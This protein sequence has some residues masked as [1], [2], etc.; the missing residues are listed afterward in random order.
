[1][2]SR[3]SR[4]L[5][6]GLLLALVAAP[7]AEA[8]PA[9]ADAAAAKRLKLSSLRA[10]PATVQVGGSF[11][12]RGRVTNLTRRRS[13][14]LVFT[15]RRS[16]KAVEL[17]SAR[18]KRPRRG[19]SRRFN[20]RIAV[21]ALVREGNY[22]FRA[23]VR[24]SGGAGKR[25]CRSRA[26][27]VTDKPGPGP[28][29]PG[30]G[31]TPPGRG[32]TPPRPGATPPGPGPTPPGP[33]ASLPAKHSLRPPLTGENFYFVMADRFYDGD[34]TNNTGGIAGDRDDHGFDPTAKGWFH[35]GDLAGLLEKLDYIEGL[36][37]SALW[38]TP[39]FKNRPVQDN[40]GF[41][42]AGYHGYWVTD[43][44]QID[45][46]FGTNQELR[47]LIDAAHER[48]IKVFFD[49]IT[50]HTADVITYE[51]NRFSYIPKDV[52]PFR[53]AS[54]T[55]FDDRDYA[56]GTFPP[57]SRTASFP[58]TPVDPPDM[59]K[60]P[61]WLNDPTMYHN[62]GNT[63]FVG[64]DS[65]YGDFFGLDDLFTERKEV[66]DGMT[67][68]Y[69]TW[70]REM[71]IDGFRIDTMKHVNDEFW[72]EFSPEVLQYAK[73]QGVEEFFMFGEVADGT[74]PLTS[75][76]TT[77]NDVQAVLDFPFQE[78]ARAFAAQSKPTDALGTFFRDDD[79]YTDAD[80][81]AYQLPTFLGN[82]DAGH[83][84][85]FIRND[86]PTGTPESELLARDELAHELM[87]LSRGNPVVYFGDEQGFTGAGN[88]QAARQDM[89]D[90]DDPEYDNVGDDA[91]LNDN[92]GSDETPADDNFDLDHPLYLHIK[93]LADLTKAH[94]ALRDGAQQH[95]FSSSEAGIYAFSRLARE[96]GREYVVALNNSESAKTATIPTYMTSTRF[97]RLWGAGAAQVSTDEDRNLQLTVPALSA[98]VYKA[99]AKLPKSDEAPSVAVIS[100][101][102]NG[103][104]RQRMEVTADVGGDS[105]YEVTFYAREGNGGWKPIGTD[106]N[107][108]YR[109]FHDIWDT[110]PGTKLQ[111]K[112]VVLDNAGHARESV[113]RNARVAKPLVTLEAP[114]EGQ[115]VR[116]TVTVRATTNPEHSDYVVRFERSV[117]G[118]AFTTVGT[119]D[120]S[121]VYTAFDDTSSLPDGAQVTYRAVL[122]YSP[123]KTV[124]SG[125]RTATI[126]QTPVTTA[127]IHYN[128]PDGSYNPWGLHLFGD[129]LAPG[130]ATAEWTA[131]TPFEGTDAY[132]AFHEIEIADDTKRVGFIVHGRTAGGGNPDTKDPDGSPDRFFIPLATPEIW[133]RQGDVRIYS[134]PEANSTCVV[135]SA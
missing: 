86:N 33:P 69:E 70:V 78:A 42:S 120:S 103:Q 15:L 30:T 1:M 45:P 9:A 98:V 2:L 75:H 38:L 102:H 90:S 129:G 92:I 24:R 34:D 84:G 106:D 54:G 57:L 123:G 82:H 132:G 68:I 52:E 41:P 18:L 114:N 124:T 110:E 113:P 50:N 31:T 81:N 118:G 83:I 14:R 46:H 62:R 109:V 6:G 122:T 67:D 128:R 5:I 80:S 105:F 107:A 117:N 53:T 23:C 73:D 127:V 100:P 119:D 85:M 63:T 125:T 87:Y 32:P 112:A 21:P 91:G 36:G 101:P 76:Y 11:R 71:K 19:R 17:R 133:L 72:Q 130:E 65:Q 60:T 99:A 44:T 66:V 126:V 40:N 89:W 55:P 77:H 16:G 25:S 135:P 79:Y 8:R 22:R 12:A 37:T 104:A 96:E 47:D 7:A 4:L 59:Q 27:R 94:P 43:F 134:C 95:R 88:D 58:Y 111:Y 56:G 28:T 49:I 97:D 93:G 74:R 20:F 61:S 39:S 29:P 10:L 115:R 51:E 131:A 13:A 3:R 48:G 35:G 116:G 64:E 26:L 121:P 108:P